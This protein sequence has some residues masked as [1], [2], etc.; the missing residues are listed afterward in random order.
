ML[1]I[2]LI[3]ASRQVD[4]RKAILALRKLWKRDKATISTYAE[5]QWSLFEAG[6][7]DEVDWLCMSQDRIV[8]RRY[9]KRLRDML[10][11][12][13]MSCYVCGT[14]LFRPKWARQVFCSDMC[15]EEYSRQTKEMRLLEE[16]AALE[17]KARRPVKREGGRSL[18]PL[19]SYNTEYDNGGTLRT[20]NRACL[21]NA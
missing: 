13:E 7:C 21:D 14:L 12:V 20:V 19:R 18:K 5:Y 10:Y 8:R 17:Q 2:N 15:R 16:Q 11:R 6:D 3:G 9:D 1:K 4:D